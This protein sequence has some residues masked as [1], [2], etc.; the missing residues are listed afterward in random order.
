MS[1]L[2]VVTGAASGIGAAATR[3]LRDR[4][5]DVIGLDRT[6]SPHASHSIEVNLADPRS[7]I[8]AADQIEGP[9]DAL[10]NVA[11]VSGREGANL[12]LRVNFLG[13]RALTQSLRPQLGEAGS[14]VNVAS[15]AGEG[16]RRREGE[17][18]ALAATESFEA[19]LGWLAEH[20]VDDD[21]AYPYSKEVLRVWT[22]L[23]AARWITGGP[24]M[25]VVNPGPVETP[26]LGEF[27]AT[28]GEEKVSDDIGR[29]GRPGTPDEVA[30]AIVWL[31][32]R[33]SGWVNGAEIAVDGG[34][35]AS[36][37]GGH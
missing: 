5:H 34:L 8:E 25:N 23:Q 3:L 10:A 26:I 16:W 35:A 13:L 28:L 6:P 27:R 14:V 22:R 37:A 18:I 19:G 29:V 21:F 2:I 4:G 24:R 11:G 32:S 17:H 30:E 36:F 1:G 20:P 15:F 9:V 12:T 31:C 33:E 7:I